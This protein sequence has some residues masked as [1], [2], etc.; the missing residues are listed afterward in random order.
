MRKFNMMIESILEDLNSLE[1]YENEIEPK[2]VSYN[3]FKQFCKS[4]DIIAELDADLDMD[5]E[6]AIECSLYFMKKFDNE[7]KPVRFDFFN[8]H[9]RQY[10][11]EHYS[12]FK[13]LKDYK[14]HH[15]VTLE[16]DI[17]S[18]EIIWG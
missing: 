13:A 12:L 8:Q 18:P 16:G 3:E 9:S 4:L 6:N 7:N 17:K 11:N 1:E 5:S 15:I 2:I 14:K 10:F